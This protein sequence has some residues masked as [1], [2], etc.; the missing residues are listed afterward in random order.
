M[1]G[2]IYHQFEIFVQGTLGSEA[3]MTSLERVLAMT[4]TPQEES[5]KRQ[6]EL[7]DPSWPLRGYLTFDKANLRYRP[8]LPL[9][10]D[11]L[12]FTLRK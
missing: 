4:E 8:E 10:L 6:S 1:E 3:S 2:K 9:S 5:H 11:G 12:T 7:V